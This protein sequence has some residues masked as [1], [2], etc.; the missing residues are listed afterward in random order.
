MAL[1][2]SAFSMIKQF[3]PQAGIR[4][5]LVAITLNDSYDSG[6]WLVTADNLGLQELILL[7]PPSTSEET[8]ILIGWNATTKAI[9][10][11]EGVANPIDSNELSGKVIVCEYIGR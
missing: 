7:K 1:A 6:G 10:A 9:T 5:G 8:G 2:Q 11:A 4:R 3:K